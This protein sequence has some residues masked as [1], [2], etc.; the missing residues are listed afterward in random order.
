MLPILFQIL[1]NLQILKKVRTPIGII[2]FYCW[3]Q[4][5]NLLFLIIHQGLVLS[6]KILRSEKFLEKVIKTYRQTNYLPDI[7]ALKL[8][9]M[10]TIGYI[11]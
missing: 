3:K 5:T 1:R 10:N 4:S 9:H 2:I 6:I 7:L 8:F 11:G